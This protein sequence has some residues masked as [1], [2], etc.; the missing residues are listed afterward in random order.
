MHETSLH[1]DEIGTSRDLRWAQGLLALSVV[2]TAA[3]AAELSM[4]MVRQMRQEGWF[5]ADE[6]L[7]LTTCAILLFGNIVH[8]LVRF[9]LARR[10]SRGSPSVSSPASNVRD[11]DPVPLVTILV[12]AY[13]EEPKVVLRTLLAS[14]F[15]T[16]AN[17]RVVLLLDDPPHPRNVEDAVRLAA[18]RAM[19]DHIA[20]MLLPMREW[21]EQEWAGFQDRRDSTRLE[22]EAARLL[23]LADGLAF[24]L[25]R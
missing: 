24:W 11:S 6:V 7:F 25:T 15:Q 19:P 9:G 5:A 14:V 18:T 1:A 2:L 21:V 10:L 16:Y 23:S 12:P 13:R 17:L 22:H 8:Q 20:A 4:S 3:A